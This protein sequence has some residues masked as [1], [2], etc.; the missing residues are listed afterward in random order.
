[1]SATHR[2]VSP[3]GEDGRMGAGGEGGMSRKGDAEGDD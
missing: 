3:G 1:M 2:A